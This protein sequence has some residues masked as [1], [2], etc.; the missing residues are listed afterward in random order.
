MV[1]GP[2]DDPWIGPRARP[3]RA[4]LLSPFVSQTFSAQLE[5]G[6]ARGRVVI[7]VE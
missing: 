2:S 7:T 5:E 4:A 6:R 1:G 3:I